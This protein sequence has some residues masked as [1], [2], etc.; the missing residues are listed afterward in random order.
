MPL[1]ILRETIMAELGRMI[2]FPTETE[3]KYLQTFHFDFNLGTTDI[4]KMFDPTQG[5]AGLHRRGLF[6]IEKH[7]KNMRMNYPAE[8][9]TAGFELTLALMT[10]QRFS[11][12]I[13][14]MDMLP[15]Q[16]RMRAI[17]KRGHETHQTI[18]EAQATYDGYYAVWTPIG[19]GDIQVSILLGNLFE[20]VQ[21]ECAEIIKL[22]EF[23]AQNES[24]HTIDAWRCLTFD[25]MNVKSGKLYECLSDTSTMELKS[26]IKLD[27][28]EYIFRFVY[29]PIAARAIKEQAGGTAGLTNFIQDFVINYSHIRV[30]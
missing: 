15:R 9:R 7:S 4:H 29:R 2:F 28:V 11:L 16:Q 21:I 22:D 1:R 6:F 27:P 17:L 25:Q 10:Q 14:L 18:L 20:W 5:L 24:Q 3:L 12:D 30:C 23:I 19:I 8:L 13:K 26:D